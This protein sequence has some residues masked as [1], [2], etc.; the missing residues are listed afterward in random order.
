MISTLFLMGACKNL[1][2]LGPAEW[3]GQTFEAVDGTRFPYRK[4]LPESE[5]RAV[6]VAVH[7]LGGATSDW[8]PL[9]E[10]FQKKGIAVYAHELRGM[11]NDPRETLR[12][13]LDRRDGWLEDFVCF[14][15][16]IE[17]THP[18]KPVI[19]YGES[20]G[21]IVT[22]HLLTRAEI[23]TLRPEGFILASPIVEID[24]KLGFWKRAGLRV[25]SWLLPRKRLRLQELGPEEAAQAQVVST[26]THEAQLERTPHAVTSFSLRLLARIWHLVNANNRQIK[27]LETPM[28]ILY[29][30][31][32]VFTP[33][34]EVEAFTAG[35]PEDLP[36]EKR[37][38]PEGYHLLLHDVMWRDVLEKVENWLE[39]VI[40]N[41]QHL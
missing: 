10:Y 7:G 4:W 35:L 13:D 20:L 8:N 9:G 11:G 5:P 40:K 25:A 24:A 18:G 14:L 22:T 3:D 32:D 33:K 38:Y 27:Q 28:L 39:N 21:G 17:T 34:A 15:R 29:S 12:G 16:R 30:G 36:V 2:R 31:H 41:R 1:D 6:M 23:A 26:T 37:F 19:W